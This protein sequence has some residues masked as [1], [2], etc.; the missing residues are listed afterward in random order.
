MRWRLICDDNVHASF[1]LAADEVLTRRVGLG[2]SVPVLRLYSYKNYC[3]LVGRFQD[4]HSELN[5]DY[6]KQ[7]ALSINRRPTGGGAI[8]MG[9]NQLGVAMCIPGKDDDTYG[10]ARELM[11]RFSEGIISGLNAL[12]VAAQF[13]RKNDIEVDGRKIAGLG[14]FRDSSGGLL[15]HSSILVDMD[16]AMMLKVL[17][18]PF[19]KIS[20]K[21]VATVAERI[22]TVCREGKRRIAISEMR[23]KISEGYQKVFNIS[24]EKDDFSLEEKEEIADLEKE[25]YLRQDWVFQT[26]HVKDS[27]GMAKLKTEK[28]LLDIRLTLAGQQ[29]KALFI[30][31]DFF[32]AENAVADLE[33]SFR[34]HSSN[35]QKIEDTLNK[36]YTL[37]KNELSSL[38]LEA[39]KKAVNQ[40]LQR[41]KILERKQASEP[42]GCFVT[43]GGNAHV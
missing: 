12:G 9:E 15:F 36:V 4:V 14:I 2:K 6:C 13:R 28:G 22:T 16:I 11:A 38:P 20:D 27:V 29:I 18:T 35:Q 39:L 37:R 7:S 40:A 8:F 5:L 32:A 10:R 21:E 24:F 25:K 23:V 26:P 3:A 17:N 1:G 33:G 31:G 30:R 19:E 42:Y 43:P 34:W 41:A